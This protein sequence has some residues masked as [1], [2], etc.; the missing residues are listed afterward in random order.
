M[1]SG[2]MADFWSPPLAAAVVGTMGIVLAL[3][4]AVLAPKLRRLQAS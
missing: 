1:S 3:L 4:L 2:A